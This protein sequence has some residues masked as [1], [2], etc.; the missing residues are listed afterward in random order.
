MTLLNKLLYIGIQYYFNRFPYYN[1]KE[2]IQSKIGKDQYELKIQSLQYNMEQQ[3]WHDKDREYVILIM[4]TFKK[5]A[6]S[7]P[8]FNGE[9][10]VDF[11]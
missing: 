10:S 11:I 6:P 5:L 3:K 7:A 2:A 9:Q 1:E 8:T 4:E